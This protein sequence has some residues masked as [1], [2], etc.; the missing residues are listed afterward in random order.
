MQK[1]IKGII[2]FRRNKLPDYREKF[3]ELAQ[4][5]S[6]DALFIACSDS[7]VVPNL[8]AST[9]PGDLF[10]IRNVGNLVPPCSCEHEHSVA[11]AIEFS[12]HTLG[13]KDIIVCGHSD[14]GAIRALISDTNDLPPHMNDWL[15]YAQGALEIYD[16]RQDWLKALP[17]Q[18]ANEI[19]Q[20]NV[21][22]QLEHLKTYSAV[23][24]KVAAGEVKLYGWWFDIA[25][26]DVSAYN[27]QLKA[28]E[29]IDEAW[30]RKML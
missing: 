17:T 15:K 23:Q 27:P 30:A 9:N 22:H 24:K 26:A 12:L 18:Y 1:L 21:I 28:F 3:K 13:V 5:Q 20:L 4:R 6:P 14:C 2:E 16:K 8:F 19:S 25:T 11:A 29:L 10:V 7:R